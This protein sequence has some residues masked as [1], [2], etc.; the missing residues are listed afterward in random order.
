MKYRNS[1]SNHRQ[2]FYHQHNIDTDFDNDIDIDNLHVNDNILYVYKHDTIHRN[3][4][5]LHLPK[6][7]WGRLDS[8]GRK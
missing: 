3:I 2:V 1:N 5:Y 8:D 7:I 6:E 4:N